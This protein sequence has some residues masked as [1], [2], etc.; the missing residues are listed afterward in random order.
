MGSEQTPEFK[1]GGIVVPDGPTYAERR[2][3]GP[4]FRVSTNAAQACDQLQAVRDRVGEFT[5]HMAAQ[6]PERLERD[7]AEAWGIDSDPERP[8]RDAMVIKYDH[9]AK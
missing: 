8:S 1:P 6:D 2:A 4:V 7:R 9:D 5:D 3:I